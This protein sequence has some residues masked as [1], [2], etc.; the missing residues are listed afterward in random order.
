M[1]PLVRSHLRLP[2]RSCDMFRPALIALL[3]LAAS[4]PSM[5]SH[6]HQDVTVEI[7]GPHGETFEQFPVARSGS[8]HRAYLRAERNARY[9][10]RVTNR[11]GDRVGLVI[12][13]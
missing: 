6:R 4:A 8:V 11:T 12:A 2:H 1:A 7:V 10:I 5:A 3:A 13:V 9:R